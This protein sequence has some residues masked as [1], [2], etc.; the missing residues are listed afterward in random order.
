MLHLP[1]QPQPS[2][3][4]VAIRA[5]ALT[6][7][8]LILAACG[9]SAATQPAPKAAEVGVVTLKSQALDVT[10][11]LPGRTVAAETA[12]IR[13][14]ISGIV[15][16]RLFAEGSAVKAGQTLYQIDPASYQ[17]TLDGAN[18]AVAKARATLQSARLTAARQA[19][20][21]AADAGS[22]QDNETAQ[23]A[24]LEAQAELKSAQASAAGA[25]LD[26]Q[27]TRITAPIGGRVGISTVTAGALVTANQTTA[28]TTVQQT[29]P[30]WVNVSQSSGELLKMRQQIA[31]GSL[32]SGA[33][34]VRLQLEDGSTYEHAG[35]LAVSGVSVDTST[36]AVTLRVKVPNPEGLLM[37]GM[38]VHVQVAQAHAP[39]A[40]LAPQTGVQR[41]TSGGASALVVGADGTVEKRA[42]EVAEVHG[43][44]WRVTSGLA[45]GDRLIV[46][47]NG[48]VRPG[49]IVSALEVG[50]ASA[51]QAASAALAATPAPASTPSAATRV[52]LKN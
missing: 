46:Q 21:L 5:V 37:P 44:Q 6:A 20:L 18:A 31:N 38:Y 45:A 13:P 49:Q 25:R 39:E 48:K 52:A 30:M 3:Y 2:A 34:A 8:T 11:E 14:Q 26:L 36:G 22:R 43:T 40:V 35:E 10:R 9:Q 19:S 23:A 1:H 24:L 4:R 16:S 27:R 50:A 41:D 7:A 17:V 51:E 15:Q 47:G 28:L 42:V 33:L 29:D 12:E 32:R